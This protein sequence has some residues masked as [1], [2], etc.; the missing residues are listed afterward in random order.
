MKPIFDYQ[1]KAWLESSKPSHFDQQQRLGKLV[2][3]AQIYTALNEPSCAEFK[4]SSN[5]HRSDFQK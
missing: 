4:I 1:I 2:V 3:L 5:A